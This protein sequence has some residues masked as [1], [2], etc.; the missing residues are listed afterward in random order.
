M[1]PVC[2][3]LMREEIFQCERG[4]LIC[5]A[6]K[7]QLQK[8]LCPQCRI[9]LRNIRSLVLEQIR[10]ESPLPC[11]YASNGCPITLKNADLKKHMET[12]S[13]KPFHC[14]RCKT[15]KTIDIEEMKQH[16]TK[17]HTFSVKHFLHNDKRKKKYVIRF[18]WMYYTVRKFHTNYFTLFDKLFIIR[19]KMCIINKGE[20]VFYLELQVFDNKPFGYCEIT[21]YSTDQRTQLSWS[22]P[23]YSVRN[24]AKTSGIRLLSVGKDEYVDSTTNLIRFDLTLYR[25]SKSLTVDPPTFTALSSRFD[26][27][28]Y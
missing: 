22:G 26:K 24:K 5:V 21:M 11:E 17:D 4:H 20:E 8:P 6:C 19:S 16:L 3:D 15:F 7:K 9:P 27:N 23:V 18:E 14:L 25:H 28:K 10:N 13:Y 2:F 12:C 1:C